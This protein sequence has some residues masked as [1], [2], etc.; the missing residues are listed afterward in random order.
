MNEIHLEI[1]ENC[2]LVCNHNKYETEATANNVAFG[3]VVIAGPPIHIT[4]FNQYYLYRWYICNSI[5]SKLAFF[6]SG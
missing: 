5:V 4:T 3:F 1:Y 2:W 6:A